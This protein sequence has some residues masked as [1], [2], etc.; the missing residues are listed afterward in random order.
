M[1]A[2][3]LAG[4]LKDLDMVTFNAEH[5]FAGASDK[6]HLSATIVLLHAAVGNLSKLKKL[7]NWV[8]MNAVLLLPFLTNVVILERETA[9]G[10]ILKTFATKIA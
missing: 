2:F 5:T 7:H 10:E 3:A 4:F 8:A 6:I 9:A 1:N